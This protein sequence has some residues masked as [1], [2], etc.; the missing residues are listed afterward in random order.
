MIRIAATKPAR[1]PLAGAVV[2][3]AM[4]V[5]VGVL[6]YWSS[7][8]TGNAAV[9]VGTLAAPSITSATPGGGSVSLAWSTVAAPGPGA[10]TYSVER[11]AGS[12]GGTCPTAASPTSVTACTD[13]GLAPGT[14]S[15]TVT[16]HWRGWTA[17]ST[18][19]AATVTSGAATQLVLTPATTSPTAGAADNLTI[20]AKDAANATVTGY[21][22]DKLL[23]FSGAGTI[24]ALQPTVTDKTGAAVA[25]GTATTI[26]FTNGVATIAG[27]SNGVMRLY[28]AEATS[29]VVG[30]GTISNGTGVAVTVGPGLASKLGFT[31]QPSG[32]TGGVAFATQ[33][34]VAVQDASGNTVTTASNSVT[35]ALTTPAGATLSCTTN[36]LAASSGVASF[37]SCK[38]NLANT[39]TLTATATGLTA[40]SSSSFVVAVGAAAKL[41]FGQQ[42][43]GSTGGVELATQPKVA[44]QDLGGNTVTTD[45]SSVTLALT[46]PAGA[47]LSCATN[48]LIA[49]AGVATFAGCKV[50]L[51]RAYT[52]T[53][54]ATGLTTAT[55]SSFTITVGVPAKLGFTQQPGA[56]TGGVAAA[57]QPKVA[58][59]DLGGNTVTT[60]TNAVTLGLT[61]PAGA[62]FSCTTNPVAATAGIATFTGCKVDLA[63]AYTLT[64]TAAGLTSATSNSFTVSVGTAVKL[65]FTQ[66]PSSS[67]GGTAFATQPRVA[68]Q[69]LGGNTVTTK[70]NAVTLALTT[71]AGA[72]FACATNP[73]AAVAGVATFAGC[74][75]DL[76]GT[77]TLT[78]TATGFT[79]ATS[80]SF[81]VAVG[82]A[83]R[84]VFS[85]QPSG[86]VANVVFD[87]QPEVTIQDLGGNTVDSDT[88]SVTLTLTTPGAATLACTENPVAATAGVA[89]FTGCDIDV[90]DDY[91][92]T[93][94]DGTLT[95]T[96]SDVITID[97][98][99]VITARTN[100]NWDDVDTWTAVAGTGSISTTTSSSTVTGTGTGFLTELAVGERLLRKNG[101]TSIGIVQSIES[102]TSLT[103]AGNASNNN[104]D[105]VFTARRVPTVAEAVSVVG[106]YTVTIPAAY[107]AVANSLT[108][109]NSANKSAQT[110]TLA[111]ATSSLTTGGD[112]TMNAPSGNNA[113]RTL[114]VNSGTLSVGGNLSLMA[115][116]NSNSS[117]RINRVT[118]TTGT[119][120]VTG[121]LIFNAGNVDSPNAAQSQLTISGAG[122]VNLAGAFTING[123]GGT[124]AATLTPGTTST[125]NFNGTAPQTIPIG[126]SGINYANLTSNNTSAS[127]ATLSAAITSTRVVGNVRVLSG[128]L[129]NGGFAIALGTSKTFQVADGATFAAT[130][131]TGMVT[132]TTLTKTFG[133]ASTV[134]YA[135]AAQTVSN[136]TYGNLSLAGSGTKTLPA[137]GPT[138]NGDLSLSGTAVATAAVALT[139]THD[140]TIGAG[141]TF[142]ASTFSHIVKGSFSSNG[143]FNAGTSTFTFNGTAA[144]TIG[145]TIAPTFNNLTVGNAAGLSLEGVDTTVGGTL[146]LGASILATGSNRVIAS[147]TVSRT[148]GFVDGR[149]QKPIATGSSTRLF[150]VGTGT[151]YTP[152]NVVLTGASA[153]GNLTASSTVGQHPDFAAS[154]ISATKYVNRYW[155]LTAGGG[156]TAAS[157]TATFTFVAA[158]LVGSPNTSALVVRRYAAP[159]TWTAPTSPSSTATT[160]TGGFTTSFGDYA[161][162]Q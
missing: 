133:P 146:A 13:T 81:E 122:T 26:T 55:S 118:L 124:P 30:D 129:D 50:N 14:Y 60:G 64:A 154:G 151:T 114:A 17:K 65:G 131:T 46:T 144:G 35:L 158:D 111:S 76:V 66:Q 53:A 83:A 43:S 57:T 117:S 119:A 121:D 116:G 126:V 113:T 38:V 63:G 159:A 160:V 139:V 130:G 45:A 19:T 16:A 49:T 152:I 69:D 112:I 44:I 93:A 18:V 61:T 37:A 52:L 9:S 80:S 107:A 128:T 105:S 34:K 103:L 12:A 143:T 6:A 100:G 138:I 58:I 149:L 153:G 97:A 134:S 3:V 72:T 21:T 67:T 157:Y 24:G 27:A 74:K 109:G 5:A 90:A 79:V 28:K 86:A 110:V 95:P 36:P 73:L 150:E 145:G 92:L 132:G 137:T 108:I 39:Y 1:L 96:D 59:Q 68:I 22:G 155:T 20:T 31:Q 142:N 123:G 87:T 85:Q 104:T 56:A 135:G 156:L 120:T 140:F 71:P 77:Y 78:A 88:S 4:A 25:F 41:A 101:S 115:G 11:G 29:I 7:S 32:S 136:E 102:D 91:T 54:T 141:S 75:V 10:I 42:P 23:T 89:A 161:A 147:G 106:K 99:G 51:A 15:Y 94:S 62:I 47:T 127:G 70:T 162:G 8:G 2:V 98:P 33:P 125:F 148:T 82:P 84:L 48:P 40:A